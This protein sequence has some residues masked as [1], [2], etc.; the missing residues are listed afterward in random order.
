MLENIYETNT[1]TMETE[2]EGLIADVS[3]TVHFVWPTYFGNM[4]YRSINDTNNL[5]DNIKR[6]NKHVNTSK[7]SEYVYTN[8]SKT[9]GETD[10]I[11]LAYPQVFGPLTSITDDYNY[12]YIEDFNRHNV[13]ITYGDK[14]I[15]Y[16]M[17]V[18]KTPAEVENFKIKFK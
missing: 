10:H 11:V 13:V 3:S 17:Y 1:Y 9:N 16:Y 4:T 18:D 2:K 14:Q 8:L 5:S 15:P 6:L 7:N 12:E